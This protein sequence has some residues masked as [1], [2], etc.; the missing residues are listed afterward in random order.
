MALTTCG[1]QRSAD[2]TME[3]DVGCWLCVFYPGVHWALSGGSRL[4]R[5][6]VRR[7]RPRWPTSCFRTTNTSGLVLFGARDAAQQAWVEI[8]EGN[9]EN[10]LD[11]EKQLVDT[12][13]AAK[14]DALLITPL[15]NKAS[16]QTVK[17]AKD[18]GLVV[19]AYNTPVD[20]GYEDAYIEC[21]P[22]DLGLQ[23]GQVAA[24]YIQE[25]LGGRSKIAILAFKS[26]VPEQSNARVGGFKDALKDLPGV[27]IVAEQDAWL[28][29]MVVQKAGD[30][31]TAHPD[32]NI[33]WLRQ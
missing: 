3:F 10:K 25:K 19:I 33:L 14:V 5:R 24:K 20:G 28:P 2:E 21:D 30:I 1:S 26:L 13:I 31:L 32:L 8:R 6:L 17:R 7:A 16:V 9:S 15:S 18:K 27:E 4:P 12:Y 11:K 29:E 23:T 22:R